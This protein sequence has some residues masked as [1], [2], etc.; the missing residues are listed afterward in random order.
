MNRELTLL[1]G[2]G[3]GAA[4]M[5]LLDP[6][7]GRTRRKLLADKL[8]ASTNDLTD[9][10]GSRARDLRNRARGV[11]AVAGSALGVSGER[12]GQSGELEGAGQQGASA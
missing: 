5:Y 10:A 4:L 12:G 6:N 2:V 11:L 1:V 7:R 9:V 8:V 3:V